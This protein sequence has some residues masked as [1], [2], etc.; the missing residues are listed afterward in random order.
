MQAAKVTF[1]TDVAPAI[2]NFSLLVFATHGVY[3]T[4]IPGIMEPVL[5]MTMVPPGTDGMLRMTEVM[6]LRLKADLVALAACQTGLRPAYVWRR[7]G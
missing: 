4:N 2:D 5:A 7:G 1:F 6:S 3:S